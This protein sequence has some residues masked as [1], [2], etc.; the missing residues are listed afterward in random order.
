MRIKSDFK[1]YYDCMARYDDDHKTLFLRKRGKPE[2]AKDYFL[3][4]YEVSYRSTNRDITNIGFE[5]HLIGFCGKF[6]PLIEVN[7]GGRKLIYDV[8]IAADVSKSR[9]NAESIRRF[10]QSQNQER[11]ELFLEYGPIFIVSSMEP[12]EYRS[13]YN[14]QQWVTRNPRLSDWGF[15]KILPPNIAYNELWKFVCNMRQPAM[16]IPEMSNDIKIHQAGFDLKTSF[17]RHKSKK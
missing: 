11:H 8:E 2:K 5:S 1:D 10:M 9:Y 14:S 17:R 6:Y 3:L 7:H 12:G 4:P 16:P 13:Y 15:A